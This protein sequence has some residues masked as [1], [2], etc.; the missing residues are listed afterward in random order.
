MN[1]KIV[2][3]IAMLVFATAGVLAQ[4]AKVAVV[5]ADKVIQ[6]SLKGK[7]FFEEFQAFIEKMR[8][9]LE[10]DVD[11]YRVAENDL[12][13]KLA[14]L[15]EEKR[16]EEAAKLQR[17][18]TELKRKQE[19]ANMERERRLQEGLDVFRNELRPLIRQVALAKGLDLVMNF[20]PN[21]NL[22]FFN[23]A[24]DITKDVIKEYDSQNAN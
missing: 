24:V 6:E 7:A 9:E 1:K 18:Q 4:G 5:D 19:D 15:S 23:D 10:A 3:T 17:M 8:Q 22:V 20:G 21:S 2:T 11:R 16:K 12:Q 14:S 13:A